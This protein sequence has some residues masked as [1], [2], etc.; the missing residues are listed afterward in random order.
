MRWWFNWLSCFNDDEHQVEINEKNIV[1]LPYSIDIVLMFFVFSF[2]E[3]FFHY[4]HKHYQMFVLVQ[5]NLFAI[6]R[7]NS[8][9]NH[10]E[11]EFDA[12][13]SRP[14]Q[15]QKWY[16]RF[17]ALLFNFS[18]CFHYQLP[19]LHFRRIRFQSSNRMKCYHLDPFTN[20]INS[21]QMCKT[22]CAVSIL[23]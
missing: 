12:I 22:V 4:K 2:Q 13:F 8:E 3:G 20:E 9:P 18:L 14:N 15:K 7:N 17:N 10:I 23:P 5:L 6:W 1:F 11:N 19:F 16:S 21:E